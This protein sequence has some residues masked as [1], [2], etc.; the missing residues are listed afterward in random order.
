MKS[1]MKIKYGWQSGDGKQLYVTQSTGSS[2]GVSAFFDEGK[3]F[4]TIQDC[5][6]HWLGKHAFP[7]NYEY[8][9]HEDYLHFFDA[10]TKQ[11]LMLI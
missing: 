6:Q 7:D 10:K 4:D 3:I 2:W 1:A 9:L 8:L 5:I 11:Q